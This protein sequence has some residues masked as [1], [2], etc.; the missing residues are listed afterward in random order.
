MAENTKKKPRKSKLVLRKCD[1]EDV[2]SDET[3]VFFVLYD[4][5]FEKLYVISRNMIQF[6]LKSNRNYPLMNYSLFNEISLLFDV[7]SEGNL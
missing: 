6:I 2:M 4:H 7:R 3:K 1:F 5:H